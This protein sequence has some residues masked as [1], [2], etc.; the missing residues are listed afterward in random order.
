MGLMTRKMGMI[1][2]EKDRKRKRGGNT[3]YK[4]KK[5]YEGKINGERN[6]REKTTSRGHL[7]GGRCPIVAGVGIESFKVV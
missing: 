1:E 5:K 2:N 6:G 4:G 3:K 7:I